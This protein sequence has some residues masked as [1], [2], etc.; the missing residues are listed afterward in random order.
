MTVKTDNPRMGRPVTNKHK[1]PKGQWRDWS[2][3]ARRVFN[4]TYESMRPSMQWAFMHPEA[5]LMPKQHW[6][7]VRWN[8][9]WQAADAADGLGP[10]SRVVAVDA[11]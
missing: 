7:T 8:A 3:T 5:P 10:L 11:R 6:E 2:N 1:V 4:V 9:A